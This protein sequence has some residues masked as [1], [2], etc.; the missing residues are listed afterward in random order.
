MDFG[1]IV[2]IIRE[3]GNLSQT[4]LAELLSVSFATI[5]RW[6]NGHAVPNR[7]TQTHLYQACE[8]RGIDLFPHILASL[9]SETGVLFHGSKTG[10]DGNIQPISRQHCDFGRGFYMGD[11]AWQPLTLICAYPESVFYKM[12]LDMDGL[13]VLDI[14]AG[15]EWALAI[16]YSRGKLESIKDTA[17]YQRYAKMLCEYDVVCGNIANDRMFYVL[18]RF[19]A[20][21]IT[22]RGL[23]EC[24]SSLQLGKQYAALTQKAC[25][26]ITILEKI[27]VPE[28]V[29]L[30]MQKTSD[31]NREQGIQNANEICRQHRRDGR[32]FDEILQTEVCTQGEIV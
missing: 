27:P 29:R 14:P 20:G 17:L 28:I 10:I 5:N 4:A 2:K 12:C 18:D 25:S 24:L 1:N 7:L 8:E 23:I 11:N 9:N 13:S 26:G 30:C 16:A 15:I 3:A 32:F 19:F 31:K 21:D 22:D 6:E